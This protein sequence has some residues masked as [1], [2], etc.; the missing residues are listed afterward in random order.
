MPI[1]HFIDHFLIPIVQKQNTYVRD[2]KDFINKV[3]SLHLKPD[4]LL[5]TYDVTSMYTNMTA[6]ELIQSA[7]KAL[8]KLKQN[9]VTLPIP[10][11]GYVTKLLKILLENNEFE[12]NGNLY[13][14]ILGTSMGAVPSPEICDLRL[15]D[16]H[17]NIIKK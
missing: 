6:T 13:K 3:E 16:I 14:Q 7:A 9:D 8:T 12:F 4:I 1:G 17:E 10:D 11:I 5:V 15:F 2:T